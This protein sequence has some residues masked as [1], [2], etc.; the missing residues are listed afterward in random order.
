MTMTYEWGKDS[1]G[2]TFK[3]VSIFLARY[4][5]NKLIKR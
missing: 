5:T 2:G 1:E 4:L 3:T